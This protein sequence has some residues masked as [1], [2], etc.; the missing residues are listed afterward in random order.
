MP[1]T[2]DLVAAP[3]ERILA[4]LLVIARRAD[5]LSWGRAGS[6]AV[7][8]VVWLQA[9]REFFESFRPANVTET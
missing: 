4:C 2:A 8:R 5:A 3:E 1:A 6:P 9:E 7:D